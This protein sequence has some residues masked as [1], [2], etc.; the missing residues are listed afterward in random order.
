M[1]FREKIK[2]LRKEAHMTQAQVAAALGVTDR[3]YQ[4]YEAG[5]STPS[6]SVLAKA[7]ALFGVNMELLTDGVPTAHSTSSREL[8]ALLAEM[9]ALF[10][11]GKLKDE[12][13]QY[14]IEALTEAFFRSKE[15]NK[16]Y[17]RGKRS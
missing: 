10:S 17:G 5:A 14:V 16:K 2:L 12:D 4:N 11:G 7:G 1:E 3:T 13:K 9:Q 15:I 6:A 8:A